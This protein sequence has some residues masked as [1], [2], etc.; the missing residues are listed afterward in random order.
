[1]REKGNDRAILEMILKQSGDK[2]QRGHLKEIIEKWASQG[3]PVP[4]FSFS[5]FPSPLALASSIL[6]SDNHV[7]WRVILK[8]HSYKTE[9]KFFQ[10]FHS[11][12]LWQRQLFCFMFSRIFPCAFDDT[13]KQWGWFWSVAGLMN[14]FLIAFCS[15][16]FIEMVFAIGSIL[17]DPSPHHQTRASRQ[18]WPHW[19]QIGKCK[20]LLYS[21]CSLSP[22]K[23]V[24]FHQRAHLQWQLICESCSV[25]SGEDQIVKTPGLFLHLSLRTTGPY[26]AKPGSPALKATS[27]SWKPLCDS[28]WAPQRPQL[29]W[30]QSL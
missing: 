17:P 28:S 24:S 9:K 30:N 19:V 27:E 16:M 2:K 10:F 18:M 23:L 12:H 20:I 14:F 21:V 4:N 5:F 3:K 29:V 22:N 26:V 13:V 6:H 8:P 15:Q 25:T 1:M 11:S 7:L